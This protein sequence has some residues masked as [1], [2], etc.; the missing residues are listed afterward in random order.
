MK[1]A[2]L[3]LASVFIFSTALIAY[4]I[5]VMRCFAVGSWSTFG[6]MVIR[7]ALL[8]FGLAGTILTFIHKQIKRN[9]AAWLGYAALLMPFAIAIA[10][11]LAQSIPFS[12]KYIATDATQWF[13]VGA[14]FTV[15]AFPFFCGAFFIGVAFIALSDRIHELY[16]WNM[17]G[18]GFGGF[19]ILVSMYLLPPNLIGLPVTVLAGI[20]ALLCFF[21][22]NKENK[23][24]TLKPV[25][26][27][28][29]MLSLTTGISLILFLGDLRIAEEKN[30]K[31]VYNLA[32]WEEE[33]HSASPLGEIRIFKSS[34]FHSAPGLSEAFSGAG[35]TM[36]DH[37]FKGMYIDG[38]GPINIMRKLNRDESVFIDYLPMSAHYTLLTA[39]DVLLIRLGGAINLFTAL[40][41]RAGHI[42][43]VEPN[44]DIIHIM[45]DVPIISAFNQHLLADP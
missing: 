15:Y 40:H 34:Y 29:S 35:H 36:P 19:F 1:Q 38:N 22:I 7:I 45:R 11:I 25:H 44:E 24:I 18:S 9:A 41:H 30:I 14:L 43:V 37:A 5:A 42:Q 6:S 27:I 16:F 8:G 33:Y 12:P 13:W 2:N 26:L 3:Q 17:C 10:Q 23:R 32:E 4:E 31:T 20:S 21:L 39:P 28:L